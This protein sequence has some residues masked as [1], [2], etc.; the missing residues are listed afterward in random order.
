MVEGA[1]ALAGEGA[2]LEEAEDGGAGVNGDARGAV[3][4]QQPLN[5]LLLAVGEVAE[6]TGAQGDRVVGAALQRLKKRKKKKRFFS[7]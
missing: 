1:A 4:H 2:V 3:A 7:K 6:A 5:A